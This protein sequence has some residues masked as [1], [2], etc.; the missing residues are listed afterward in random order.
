VLLTIVY[1]VLVIGG[2]CLA[3]LAGLEVVQHRV[4]ADSRQRHNDVAC[5]IYAAMSRLMVRRLT[6][7]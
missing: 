3:A 2:I 1:G 5:F 7:A 6:R 4:P